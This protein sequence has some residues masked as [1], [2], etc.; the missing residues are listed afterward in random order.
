MKRFYVKFEHY[1]ESI[2]ALGWL[3]FKLRATTDV[4]KPYSSSYD[5]GVRYADVNDLEYDAMLSELGKER[6]D[7][8]AIRWAVGQV[9]ARLRSGP[10]PTTA[11][12]DTEK[13]IL[14][15]ADCSVLRE[16]ALNKTCEYQVGPG[17]DLLLLRAG[18]TDET[19]VGSDKLKRLAPTSRA[20]CGVCDM[21]DTDELCSHLSHPQVVGIKAKGLSSKRNLI[22]AYCAIGRTE[23]STP[24]A[25]YAGGYLMR[26]RTWNLR[27]RLLRQFHT[28]RATCRSHW[29][30]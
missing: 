19:A 22:S 5:F 12:K 24:T 30:S 14:T 7:R 20:L 16:L 17:R 9:E 13:L 8:A 25:C 27:P 26:T 29:T 6:L 28:R 15:E 1:D 23:V 18:S 4:E 10:A 3:P 11:P 2:R 21:P